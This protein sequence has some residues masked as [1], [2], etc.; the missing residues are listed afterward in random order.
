[1]ATDNDISD[2]PFNREQRRHPD[3]VLCPVTE[4]AHLIGCGTTKTRELIASGE[5]RAVRIDRRLLVPRVEIDDFVTRK[6][7]AL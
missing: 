3:R 4:T 6:L 5:L 2:I 7:D 1:M